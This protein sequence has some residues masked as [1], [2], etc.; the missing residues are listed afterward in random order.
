MPSLNFDQD[1]E[2][3]LLTV[4]DKVSQAEKKEIFSFSEDYKQFLDQGKTEREVVEL[5]VSIAKEQGFCALA[6][7]A[8][9][10]PGDKV[11]YVNRD[12]AIVLAVIGRDSLEKGIGFIG[13]HIDSP[14]LDLKP[15]P[16]YEDGFLALFKTHYYGGIKKYHWV[17]IPL[18]LHG[19]VVRQDGSRVKIVIGED[20]AD[21]H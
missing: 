1:S 16:L 12:K 11:F 5:V 18:A 20:P 17:G 15:E 3:K 2:K 21:P 13:A 8:T 10:L 14:R 9:L 6:E 7:K 4:W 19:V